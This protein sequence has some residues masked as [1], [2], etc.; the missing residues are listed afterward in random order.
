MP[1]YEY[2]AIDAAGKNRRGIVDADTART[3]RQKLR[4]SGIY[5]TRL[6]ETSPTEART[7]RRRVDLRMLRQRVGRA[8]LVTTTR[9]LATLL[10]AGLPLVTALSGVLEQVSKPALRRVLSQ[11]R[12]RVN[13]G[14][15]LSVALGE[16]P[17][18]F[19]SVYAAMI[20]AGESSGTLELVMERLADFGEQQMA[21][22]RK[23]RANLAYPTLMLGVGLLVVL[24]L[25]TYV[26]PTITRIFVEMKRSLPLPTVLLIQISAFFQ[27]VWP[28]LVVLVA[29]AW[30]AARF[31]VKTE[32]G[33]RLYDQSLLRLPIGGGIVLRVI[34]ARITRTLGTLLGNGVPLLT[35][36]EIV[37]SLVGNVI[38]GEVIDDARQEISEGATITTPLAR[39]GVFPATVIQMISVGEQSG[40]LEGMLFKIAD[41][42]EAEIETRIT[43]LTSLLEP[44][45]I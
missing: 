13:E 8:E 5:P 7:E 37:R 40:N 41:T 33:R 28:L 4:A 29:F 39:G 27:K 38:L 35:A 45:L 19:P 44:V 16:H 14:S 43:T 22:Q 34:I 24:F 23:I 17:A 21:I 42:Y 10:T 20:H 30:I 1:V 3:A 32:K 15:S 18:V 6:D 9:Q 25:M 36:L 11:V 31:Y 12:E 26:I 2:V